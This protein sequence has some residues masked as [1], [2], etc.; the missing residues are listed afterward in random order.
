MDYPKDIGFPLPPTL[1]CTV[2]GKDQSNYYKQPPNPSVASGSGKKQSFFPGLKAP[3]GFGELSSV[4]VRPYDNCKPLYGAIQGRRPQGHVQEG[5][6]FMRDNTGPAHEGLERSDSD[7]YERAKFNPIRH[8]SYHQWHN[9]D[10]HKMTKEEGRMVEIAAHYPNIRSGI[11]Q[12]P[13]LLRP[14]QLAQAQVSQPN[15]AMVKVFS[16]SELAKVIY[17]HLVSHREALDHLSRTCQFH[18]NTINATFARCDATN[19]QFLGLDTMPASQAG[20]QFSDMMIVSPVR[21][22][23]QKARHFTKSTLNEVGYPCVAPMEPEP[24][25]FTKGWKSHIQLMSMIAVNGSIL[26]HLVLH[27]LPWLEIQG[28]RKILEACPNLES[29]GVHQCF[30]LDFSQS[31]KFF[32]TVTQVNQKREA[33]GRGKPL[34]DCDFGPF[35]FK[36]PEFTEDGSDHM[37]E[38]GVLPS[39]LHWLCPTQAVGATIMKVYSIMG[40]DA[41]KVGK[42]YRQYLDRLPWGL[43]GCIGFLRAVANL[44]AFE[45]HEY[46]SGVHRSNA[47]I[48]PGE[49]SE[50]PTTSCAVE[51]A[52]QQ[53]LWY[54][55]MVAAKGRAMYSKC[56]KLHI[57]HAGLVNNDL[58]VGCGLELCPFFFGRKERYLV[59]ESCLICAACQLA[60]YMDNDDCDWRMRVQ[61][62]SRA[63]KLLVR[64][65]SLLGIA[66]AYR[67]NM[68]NPP[69]AR[70]VDKL[71]YA[72]YYGLEHVR[73]ESQ[74]AIDKIVAKYAALGKTLENLQSPMSAQDRKQLE[75][76][77]EIEQSARLCMGYYQREP[78]TGGPIIMDSWQKAISLYRALYTNQQGILE[79]RGPYALR[80]H[81]DDLQDIVGRTGD[82]NFQSQTDWEDEFKTKPA[83]YGGMCHTTDE[84]T[85]GTAAQ[86]ATTES[87]PAPTSVPSHLRHT[88]P[89]AMLSS[90]QEQPESSSPATL[91]PVQEE[92][93]S[94]PT[95]ADV[96]PHLRR[97]SPPSTSPPE[98]EEEEEAPE[99]PAKPIRP[100]LRGKF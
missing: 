44:F 58:C 5:F 12:A 19:C 61:R 65:D 87:S 78:L 48:L 15:G 86:Q 30:L 92:P 98:D 6:V 63:R 49:A 69:M 7:D 71:H 37:G 10:G 3:A 45:N 52:M 94:P 18:M 85:Y 76:H 13:F 73:Q 4:C 17:G 55:I 72:F 56:L 36:G 74:D 97:P 20:Q 2:G 91:P 32:Q 84:V 93:E 8:A 47:H 68:A 66:A 29:I 9:Y 90:V 14:V 27:G 24:M 39:V 50:L 83:R 99:T 34:I 43:G 46:H 35:W 33:E 81:Y 21:P 89:S 82:V 28:V 31:T 25:S 53:T 59:H 42:A 57:T 77:S 79:N 96:P 22:L 60:G 1:K 23:V 41:F 54:D 64:H 11:L 40:L 75:K 100:H 95:P 67:Q 26:K 51:S 16:V 80:N 38:Y 88:S 62:R 70:R